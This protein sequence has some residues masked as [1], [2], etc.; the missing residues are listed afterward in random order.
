MLARR[1]EESK[2]F[3]VGSSDKLSRVIERSRS[4]QEVLEAAVEA[5]GLRVRAGMCA[6][7]LE[8]RGSDRLGLR[9]RFG[10]LELPADVT[11]ALEG[12]GGEPVAEARR[13]EGEGATRI[14]IPLVGRGHVFGAVVAQ[15][16]PGKTFSTAQSRSLTVMARRMV[17]I[18]GVGRLMEAVQRAESDRRPAPPPPLGETEPP[19]RGE[20]VIQ[21]TVAS[22]GIAIGVAA[23]RRGFPPDLV[24]ADGPFRGDSIERAR[25]RD[26][27][28]K[29]RNDV[30]RIEAEA[31]GEL[32]EEHALIF[33]AHQ[34]LLK[35]P[36]LNAR[37]DQDIALGVPAGIAVDAALR[38]LEARIREVPDRYIQQRAD[39]LDDL[40]CRL[41]SH[42]MGAEQADSVAAHIVVGSRI[43]P[44]L[45]MEMRAQRAR[46][47]A[48]EAGGATSHAALLA[49][50]FEVPAVTGAIGLVKH[51]CSGDTVIVDGLSGAVIVRPSRETLARYHAI[52]Q[53]RERRRTGFAKYR[54]KPAET[55][56]GVRVSIQANVAL[57]TDIALALDNGAEGVGLYRTEF[58]FIVRDRFPERDEQV[59]LYRKVYDLFGD[60]PITF[61][62]L[63]LSADKFISTSEANASSCAFHGY[64]SIRVLFDYPHVLREQVQAF[65][66]AAGDRP[67]RVLVP[68]VSSLDELRRVKQLIAEALADLGAT[69]AQRCPQIGAMIEVPAA[70]ELAPELAAEVDFFS[71]GTNDLIQYTL[72][73]DRDDSRIA[74]PRDAYHPA[75]LRMVRRVV[76]AAHAAGKPV[77]V[78]GEIASRPDLAA[79]LVALDIDA[80]S[81]TPQA[82]PELKQA[83][84]CVSMRSVVDSMPGVL[85]QSDARGVELALRRALPQELFALDT[86][87]GVAPHYA[88]TN[89]RSTRRL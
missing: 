80:L 9:A 10:D 69:R 72:V 52:A 12:L 82:I 35:D 16:R 27:F 57:A 61:R 8:D 86:P 70:V 55:A 6:I 77:T 38:H 45:V 42:L 1:V 60:R 64:R 79:A 54:D 56:D 44:S 14:T 43:S 22:P 2:V 7:Y 26:T 88:A 83:L 78:C 11:A 48:S 71:I 73:I 31:Q 53:E 21:G 50:A 19:E 66:I 18:V 5:I 28:Q 63:D 49:Q 24:R 51:L 30:A 47:F 15:S 58:A 20:I 29:T 23:F 25:V 34:M 46:G 33:S 81:V 67:L 3:S 13:E 36:M 41:L 59:H 84:A 37:I 87:R 89:C 39:D 75:I 76:T 65:A 85:A 62:L 32:G 74:S 17:D 68:M 4:F 40:R